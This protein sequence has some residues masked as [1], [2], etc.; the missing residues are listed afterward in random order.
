MDIY[1]ARQPIFD[2][3]MHVLGYE[4]LYRQS[5]EN[6]FNSWDDNQATEELIYNAFA[7]LGIETLTGGTL[8]FINFSKDLVSKQLPTML[9]SSSVVIEVLERAKTTPETVDAC[10]RLREAGYTIALDDFLPDEDNL[11]LLEV[12]DIIK[13]DYPSL[14]LEM[15]LELIQKY[16]PYIK[17]LAEKI[18]TREDYKQASEMGYDFFQGYFFSKPTIIDAKEIRSLPANLMFILEELRLP[19]PSYQKIAAIIEKDLGLSYK[20][21]RLVNSAYYGARTKITTISHALVYVGMDEMR[22][23]IFILMLRGLRNPENAEAIRL[24]IVRSKLMELIALELSAE[25]RLSEYFLTGMFS[26][27]DVLMN[28]PMKEILDELPFSD[29]V[30]QAL[31]GEQNNYRECLDYVIACEEGPWTDAA[32]NSPIALDGKTY[33]NLYREALDWAWQLGS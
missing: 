14:S 5:N 26:L 2:R 24:C 19:E 11:P 15:Q 32:S 28:R 13:I 4:L 33:M 3:Q 20:L 17:F 12:A 7:V 27:I 1:V 9:P 31:L 29:E 21:L 30:K 10:R 22:K 18:E 6:R 8:A 23:F 25:E 16:R